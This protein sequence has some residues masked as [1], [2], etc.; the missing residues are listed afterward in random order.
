MPASLTPPLNLST[1]AARRKLKGKHINE[2]L[3]LAS[4]AGYG[5]EV[6]YGIAPLSPVSD[7]TLVVL[8]D[9]LNKVTRIL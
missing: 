2:V 6:H 8:L 9:D 1:K 3:E 4:R 5:V 7:K